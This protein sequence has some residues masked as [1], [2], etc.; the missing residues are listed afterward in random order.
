MLDDL[1]DAETLAEIIDES[2]DEVLSLKSALG[3]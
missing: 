2:E 3:A 1:F